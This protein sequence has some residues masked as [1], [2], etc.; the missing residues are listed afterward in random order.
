MKF[1]AAVSAEPCPRLSRV[2]LEVLPPCGID[3]FKESGVFWRRSLL[4]VVKENG[5]V[6]SI[7][8]GCL[9]LRSIVLV[10]IYLSLTA[11]VSVHRRF[12]HAELD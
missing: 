8:R 4:G 2:T 9:V 6:D 7:S 12:R 5:M 1:A 11:I 3:Q 10:S